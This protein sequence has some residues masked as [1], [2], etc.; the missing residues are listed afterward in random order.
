MHKELGQLLNSDQGIRED[1]GAIQSHIEALRLSIGS[2]HMNKAIVEQLRAVLEVYEDI[3]SKIELETIL[4][5]IS[6]PPMNQRY[7]NVGIAHETTFRWIFD[8]ED[9]G[10]HASEPEYTPFWW[11]YYEEVRSQKQKVVAERQN[12]AKKSFTNWL[13]NGQGI[14]YISGK[15][16]AG[17]ST[18]MKYLCCHD[19]LAGRLTTWAGKDQ[20]IFAK[21]FFWRPEASQSSWEGLLR[22]LLAQVMSQSPDLLARAFPGTFGRIQRQSGIPFV[23]EDQDPK[24]AFQNLFR[25]GQPIVGKRFVFFIDGLDEYRGNHKEMADTL[26]SW[27]QNFPDTLKLCVSSRESNIF[28]TAFHGFPQF[29]IHELTEGDISRLVSS[30]INSN[31]RWQAIGTERVD[32]VV[33]PIVTKAEGVFLWVSLVLNAVEEGLLNGDGIPE[34]ENKID[35]C[36][37]ELEDLFDFLLKT[38]HKCDRKWAFAALAIVQAQK[39]MYEPMMTLFQFSFLDDYCRDKNFPIEELPVD[40]DGEAIANRIERTKRQLIGRCRGLLD[41]RHHNS[42]SSPCSD[43]VLFTH[44]SIIEFMD[45]PGVEAQMKP[46]MASFDPFDAICRTFLAQMK[47]SYTSECTL[48]RTENGTLLEIPLK[49]NLK[50]LDVFILARLLEKLDS[51]QWFLFLDSI[52]QVL[53]SLLPDDDGFI[54][55][56][57]GLPFKASY[58]ATFMAIETSGYEYLRWAL[59][60]NAEKFFSQSNHPHVVYH[61]IEHL[62]SYNS[63]RHYMYAIP[64]QRIIRT[65]DYCFKHGVSSNIQVPFKP[66]SFW[67]QALWTS[68]IDSMTQHHSVAALMEIFLVYGA[69]S[70]FTLSFTEDDVAAAASS[71]TI[72]SGSDRSEFVELTSRGDGFMIE[73]YFSMS[74]IRC[75]T[76]VEYLDPLPARNVHVSS[77]SKLFEL[78][79]KK[80]KTIKLHD[81]VEIWVP[82]HAIR[83]KR[84][85]DERTLPTTPS[86]RCRE[87]ETLIID[88]QDDLN[89][90]VDILSPEL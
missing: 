41:V 78:A 75:Q 30:R 61:Y 63:W 29:K 1:L 59:G 25:P 11:I 56:E 22:G 39:V 54:A 42:D 15:P 3:T 87:D 28:H 53:S 88:S 32:K 4:R 81:L 38:I 57:L 69:S 82:K 26:L 10:V 35:T 74:V 19:E 64:Q 51:L 8:T 5:N 73:S 68:L 67:H 89:D 27:T 76:E 90:Q 36:P 65:L 50:L 16:G 71:S 60:E 77:G 72:N 12:S 58:Y 80:G 24:I 55:S 49:L 47:M 7:E 33:R 37:T 79:Q 20:L 83:L 40:W 18:L 52:G 62:V 44:R 84:L 31:P 2:A 43:I 6:I 46:Y 14:F 70:D 17:K 48:K 34:L 66:Y 9:E 45:T 86:P 21:F 23:F 13:E 85:M